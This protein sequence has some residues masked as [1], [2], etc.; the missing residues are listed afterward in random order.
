MPLAFHAS[1][2]AKYEQQQINAETYILPFIAQG[3]TIEGARVLEIGCGEGG[4]LQP[5]LDRGCTCVGIDLSESKIAYAREAFADDIASGRA[6]F[7]AA[8]IY[9]EAAGAALE[10]RFDIV[11][12]KDTIEHVYGHTR[13]LNRVKDF[14]ADGG[15]LFVGFPPWR[16]PYGGHQQ[17]TESRLGKLPWYHL[18][19]RGAYANLLKTF[20]ESD[21]RIEG[22]MAVMDT[23]L[24]IN[25]FERMIS[26]TGY[27]V[28]AVQHY[29]VNPIYRYKFG[30]EPRK[31]LRFVTAI[32][33]FR[34]FV[35][36]TCYYLLSV[37]AAARR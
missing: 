26:E 14:L 29:L 8:D 6:E 36:T 19:P 7:I 2:A 12:M 34:D 3:V 5:F 33:W 18:L 32:P 9:E 24:S 27:R 16:M 28:V 22:L 35:T 13:I 10:G 30:L 31:Q 11:I 37:R 21:E 20:G 23:R 17:M 4:I 25:Q 15:V 1:R